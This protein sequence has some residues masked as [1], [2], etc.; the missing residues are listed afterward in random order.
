MDDTSTTVV[1]V[2]GKVKDR[3]EVPVDIAEDDKEYLIKT[4]LPDVK[5]EDV[6]VTVEKGVLTISG[7]R[8]HEKEEDNKRF[9]RIEPNMIKTVD[10]FQGMLEDICAPADEADQFNKRIRDPAGA[11]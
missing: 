11:K 8:R 10:G 4:D 5:K 7:E 2:K 6:K 9:H 3:L 1:Q